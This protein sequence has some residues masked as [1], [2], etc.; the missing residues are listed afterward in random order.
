MG[1]YA[2]NMTGGEKD[3]VDK[4]EDDDSQK[5]D[6]IQIYRKIKNKSSILN[7]SRPQ[8]VASGLVRYY[9]LLKD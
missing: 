3:A 2:P 1:R 5:H 9:I 8:S 6:V 4:F 7:R